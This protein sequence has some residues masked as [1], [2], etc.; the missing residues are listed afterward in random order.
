MKTR[1]I[2]T[3]IYDDDWFNTLSIEYKFLF[4]YYFTNSRIEHTGIYQCPLRIISF[5]TGITPKELINTNQKFEA[6]K[7]ILFLKDWIYVIK[8]SIYGG[9]QGPKNELAFKREMDKLPKDI[10]ESFNNTV[11]IQYIYP[12]YTTI[13]HKS[14]IINNKSEIRN[15]KW[16]F[17]QK[18]NLAKK[19]DVKSLK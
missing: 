13:N 7:K 14:E 15:Q 8:S 4:I 3:K 1:I 17:D 11:P 6:D 2:W 16:V 18:K 5:E 12:I 19:V 9:Y 10:K